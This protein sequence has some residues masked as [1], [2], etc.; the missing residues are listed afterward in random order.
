MASHRYELQIGRML[1][2]NYRVLEFLG[3]GWEGEVYK[4][5]ERQTGIVRAAKLFYAH[6]YAKNKKPSVI[7]AKKLYELRHCPVVIQYHNQDIAIVKKEI[8]DFLISDF[9]EGE[10]LSQYIEKQKQARLPIFEAM[11]LFHAL[12]QGVEQIHFHGEYHGDIH[13]DN[14]IVQRKGLGFEVKL[15]DL[16]HLGK[17]SNQKIQTDVY[18]LIQVLYEMLNGDKF[19]AKLPI[20]IKHLILGR[21]KSLISKKFKEAGHLRLYLDNLD[22][23]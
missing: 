5:E 10:V 12:V 6:R 13:T 3:K 7:Y 4:V 18:D 17:S 2:R 23:D 15:I 20:H 11:H 1:G 9:V 21:K 19:Y 16:L 8:T 14:I 22:W